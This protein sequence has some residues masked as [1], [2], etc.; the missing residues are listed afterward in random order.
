MVCCAFSGCLVRA[1]FSTCINSTG[2][3]TPAAH[4]W[5]LFSATTNGSIL[6]SS[7]SISF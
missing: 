6:S 7:N 2:I 4:R 5:G 1:F 3:V